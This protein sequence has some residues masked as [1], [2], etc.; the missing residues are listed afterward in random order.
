LRVSTLSLTALL[1][2]VI[3]KDGFLVIYHFFSKIDASTLI[4]LAIALVALSLTLFQIIQ[5]SRSNTENSAKGIVATVKEDI[6]NLGKWQNER[7]EDLE[8]KIMGRLNAIEIKVQLLEG[9]FQDISIR[10]RTHE[11]LP[12][13]EKLIDQTADLVTRIAEVKALVM[14]VL[15]Y[16]ELNHLAGSI[17]STDSIEG[18]QDSYGKH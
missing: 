15:R 8:E 3:F 5:A 12:G 16:R 4:N 1:V 6:E 17:D 10:Q 14:V 7:V 18:G 13:H 11:S 2:V 9:L